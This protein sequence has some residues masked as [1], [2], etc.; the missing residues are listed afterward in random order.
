M[1]SV[2]KI[3]TAQPGDFWVLPEEQQNPLS[4]DEDSPAGKAEEEKDEDPPLQ[5]GPN[6]LHI[7]APICLGKVKEVRPEKSGIVSRTRELQ[8]LYL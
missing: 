8:F 5:D 1:Q 7:L 2:D 4:V 3:S 6:S